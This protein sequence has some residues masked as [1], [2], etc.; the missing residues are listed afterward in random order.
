MPP[1]SLI[2]ALVTY[3]IMAA[4]IPRSWEW[5]IA[6][7]GSFALLILGVHWFYRYLVDESWHPAP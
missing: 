2:L 7:K 4:I 3:W 1:M 6:V 5:S